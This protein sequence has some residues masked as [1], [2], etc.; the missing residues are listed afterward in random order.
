VAIYGDMAVRFPQSPD[1]LTNRGV[2]RH[3]LGEK[4][5]ACEDWKE[6]IKLG[7]DKAQQYFSKFCE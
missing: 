5:E 4:V 1:A 6:A 7:S 2:A 3:Y